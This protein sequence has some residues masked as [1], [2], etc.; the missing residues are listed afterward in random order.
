MFNEQF[1]HFFGFF[2]VDLV[3]RFK[4]LQELISNNLAIRTEAR[5]HIGKSSA[6]HREDLGSNPGKG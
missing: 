2:E 5:W 1:E 6:S 3:E 4:F